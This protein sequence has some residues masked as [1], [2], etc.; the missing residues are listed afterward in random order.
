MFYTKSHL[1]NYYIIENKMN[2]VIID[3]YKNLK[4][5]VITYNSNKI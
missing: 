1:S 3:L 5:F 4:R 2:I